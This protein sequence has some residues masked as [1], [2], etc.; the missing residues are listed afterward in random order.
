MLWWCAEGG[1]VVRGG[2]LKLYTLDF[3][4]DDPRRV[5]P[6]LRVLRVRST[7]SVALSYLA[8]VDG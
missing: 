7:G 3:M 6:E 5:S 1:I 8:R 4:M 2:L